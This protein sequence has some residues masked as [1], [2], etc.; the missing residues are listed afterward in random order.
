MVPAQGNLNH[1]VAVCLMGEVGGWVGGWVGGGVADVRA[2][3]AVVVAQGDLNHRVAVGVG[4]V[5]G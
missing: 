5:G 1:R 4:W 2:V 3:V